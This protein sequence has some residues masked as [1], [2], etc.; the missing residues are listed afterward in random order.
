M[1]SA[2]AGAL[3]L[4]GSVIS[5]VPVVEPYAPATRQFVREKLAEALKTYSSQ[6]GQLNANLEKI[7]ESIL[8]S[9]LVALDGQ[10]QVVTGQ[11]GDI[12]VKLRA[13]PGDQSLEGLRQTIK[14]SLDLLESQRR[15]TACQKLLTQV[16]GSVCSQ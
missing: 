9:R 7:T 13:T 3:V 8:D 11:L 2:V 10:I 16:P 4:L 14:N 15:D 6:Y 1:F 12:E 5:T